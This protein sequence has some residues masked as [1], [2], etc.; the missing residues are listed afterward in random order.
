MEESVRGDIKDGKEQVVQ[1][2]P[3]LV[4]GP[5][6]RVDPD[7]ELVTGLGRPSQP[8]P[9]LRLASRSRPLAGTRLE[10]T[11]SP[12]PGPDWHSLVSGR[13][14]RSQAGLCQCRG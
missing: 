8:G 6:A 9:C 14:A 4:S 12:A 1:V 3:G 5:L 13:P 10:P 7:S 11:Q 2:S